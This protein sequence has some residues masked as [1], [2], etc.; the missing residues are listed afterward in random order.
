LIL[1][2][3]SAKWSVRLGVF[4]YSLY[5]MH[6]LFIIYYGRLIQGHTIHSLA[7]PLG[8]FTVCTLASLGISYLFF[9]VVE[10]RF[11]PGH[12]HTVKRDIEATI[13][14]PAP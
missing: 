7:R 5:L 4:S 12:L 2:L 9:L 1:Q 10:R 11:L 8:F 13:L 14:S 6:S 3:L